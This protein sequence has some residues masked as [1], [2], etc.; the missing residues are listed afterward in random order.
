MGYS[1]NCNDELI[2]GPSLKTGQYFL[3]NIEA[4]E[5][6]I[7][8]ESGVVSRMG[9]DIEIDYAKLKSFID[10]VLD[11][12]EK[13][14]NTPILT[15]MSGIAELLLALEANITG[16]FRRKDSEPTSALIER[17]KLVFG[18]S[19]VFLARG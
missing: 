6:L 14:N 10:E 5:K 3:T 4:L 9:D 1:V 2:W 16:E 7:G 12:F 19:D 13:S 8:K 11:E 18:K 17:S 15:I